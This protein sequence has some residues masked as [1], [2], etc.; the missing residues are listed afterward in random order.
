MK[1]NPRFE[2][3]TV[4]QFVDWVKAMACVYLL[5]GTTSQKGLLTK[6]QCRAFKSLKKKDDVKKFMESLTSVQMY[7]AR[8][9]V[10]FGHS[11]SRIGKLILSQRWD[12]KA[13][14]GQKEGQFLMEESIKSFI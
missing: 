14:A 6:K 8:Q 9:A 10:R 1:H 2:T 11:K 4:T 5:V 12:K 13:E 3:K 7:I